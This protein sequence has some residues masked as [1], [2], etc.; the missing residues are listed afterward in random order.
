M[1]TRKA[2]AEIVEW[3]GANA[4]VTARTI[5]AP[6]P[7]A[8]IRSF[9]E[10][11]PNGWPK[12]LSTLYRLFDG[13]EPSTA[14]YILPSYRPLPLKEAEETRQ[15]L[16]DVWARVGEEA[17]AL[18][19]Q[20]KRSP[21]HVNLR[22]AFEAY[23]GALAPTPHKPYDPAH[24]EAEEAGTRVSMFI[25]SFLPVADDGSGDFL[26]VD[27]RKGQQYG[28]VSEYFK[29]EAD[30]RPAMWPSLDALLADTLLSLRTGQPALSFMPTVREG[31]LHWGIP[32]GR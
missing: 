13:A 1:G 14:G 21:L 4:P 7:E 32:P 18:D 19:K 16:L 29:E 28:C 8:F 23:G 12:D 3:L 31:R 2:W 5:R 27:L 25:P 9:E 10:A 22:A 24:A 6:A 30:W 11:A 15:M 17:N 20:E 26:F